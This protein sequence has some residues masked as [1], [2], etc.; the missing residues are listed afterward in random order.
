ML[1]N[2]VEELM[3][4]IPESR[5]W[6]SNIKREAKVNLKGLVVEEI[7]GK[8]ISPVTLTEEDLV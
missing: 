5:K 8:M 3:E 2:Y 6:T 4:T 1:T 7:K